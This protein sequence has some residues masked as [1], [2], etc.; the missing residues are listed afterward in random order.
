MLRKREDHIIEYRCI[1][2]GNGEI[3][4]HKIIE[5]PEELCGKG[6]LFNIMIM[7]PGET[8]GEHVHKGEE[9]IF[10]F[11]SGT[12]EYNDNG[13]TVQVGHGDTVFCCDGERHSM[14]NTGDEPLVFVSLI[15]YS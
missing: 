7:Q 4:G 2:G 1:H 6:R 11:L 3:E 12:A 10:H 5:C 9:E 8:I 15:V 14:V 13:T